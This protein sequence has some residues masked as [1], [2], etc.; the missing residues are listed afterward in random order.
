[1]T[2]ACAA[3]GRY[4][5]AVT[6]AALLAVLLCGCTSASPPPGAAGP[7]E[8]AQ[9]FAAAVQRGDAAAAY[10]LLSSRTQKQADEIAAR[11][12]AA[13][14]DAGVAPASGR[15]MLFTSALPQGKVEVHRI[16]QEANTAV[17]EV[18]GAGGEVRRFRAVRE[19]GDWKLD[20]D[21]PAGDGG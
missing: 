2:V 21:L 14:A 13:A 17:V 7:V 8:A 19:N 11:A 1:M 3:S 18:K 6:R 5:S 12:R 15:Q 20:L 4:W 10:A 16:S 9:D